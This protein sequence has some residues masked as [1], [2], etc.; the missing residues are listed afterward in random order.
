MQGLRGNAPKKARQGRQDQSNMKIWEEKSNCNMGVI[1]QQSNVT[2]VKKGT[3]IL[4]RHVEM[5]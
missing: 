3:K 1:Q 4:R 2:L 5:T